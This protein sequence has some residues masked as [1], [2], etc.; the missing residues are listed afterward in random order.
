MAL[1]FRV[2]EFSAQ[3]PSTEL[4]SPHYNGITECIKST[5]PMAPPEQ[6]EAVIVQAH[7]KSIVNTKRSLRVTVHQ[8]KTK[9]S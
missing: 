1:M 7:A 9:K 2:S 6:T 3:V 4:A 5:S 8:V